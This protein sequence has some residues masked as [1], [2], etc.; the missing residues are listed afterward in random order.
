MSGCARVEANIAPVAA[1]FGE[2]SRAAILT[3]LLDGRALPAGELASIA[4]IN[5]TAASGHLLKLI[6]GGLLAVH[7]EGRHRYYRL[8]NEAVATVIED[9][10]QL[11]G[12]PPILRLPTLSPA[13]R[14]LREARTCYDHLAGQVSVAI[15]AAL[16]RRGWLVRGE[17]K[18]YEIGNE[19]GR[20]WFA[21]H[22]VDF[23]TIKPG[24]HGLARQCLDW[25]E[26]R[27][28]VAGPIGAQL[29]TCWC[30]RGWLERETVRSRRVEITALGRRKLR[31]ELG[32]AWQP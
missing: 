28:H 8:A 10:A 3:V 22:G 18:R 16:E 5:P 7:V 13:V 19:T 27:P 4:G 6:N 9:L 17:G 15:A 21:R 1:L 32:L 12:S 25:T 20:Q 24:R 30:E 11:S 29:F 14:A 31:Q 26:R 2:P 23:A